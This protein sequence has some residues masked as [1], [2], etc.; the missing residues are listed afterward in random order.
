MN[1]CARSLAEAGAFSSSSSGGGVDESGRGGAAGEWQQFRRAALRQR[2]WSRSCGRDAAQ[3]SLP[4]GRWLQARSQEQ[5][6]GARAAGRK[7][8][9]ACRSIDARYVSSV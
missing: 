3:G 6:A 7:R 5:A 2:E 8:K 1:A 9:A 4:R